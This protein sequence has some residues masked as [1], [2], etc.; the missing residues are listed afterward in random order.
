M[1][2]LF[3]TLIALVFLAALMLWPAAKSFAIGVAEKAHQT[4]TGYMARS[5]LV[6]TLITSTTK[7]AQ[8]VVR[9]PFSYSHLDDAAVPALITLNP[10]F[11]PR[12][13]CVD[14]V[15]DR[16]K[17]EWYDGMAA[18]DYIKTVAAGTRTIGTD[19]K[20]AVVVADGSQPSITVAA[21]EVLQNKQYR[22]IAF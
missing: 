9:G 18:T 11:K 12:Y 20:L 10:G 17:Y 15:T 19:S 1:K 22:C 13:V 14:N 4:L 16:I 8:S 21:S 2:T 6:L 5:G 3:L 7:N